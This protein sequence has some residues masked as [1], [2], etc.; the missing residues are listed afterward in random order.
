MGVTFVSFPST[1]YGLVD[2]TGNYYGPVNTA[3]GTGQI[4]GI[5]NNFEWGPLVSDDGVTLGQLLYTGAGT[6][7]TGVWESGL[8]CAELIGGMVDNWNTEVTFTASSTRPQ[9]VH[10]DRH[11]G[12]V[13][14]QPGGHHLGV[15]H[16]LHRGERPAR[17]RRRPRGAPRRRSPSPAPCRPV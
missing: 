7:A 14:Q 13:R 1:G 2:N 6:T 11:A 8:V 12:P 10:L 17:S 9:R 16:D 5:P 3:I 4:V 15:V